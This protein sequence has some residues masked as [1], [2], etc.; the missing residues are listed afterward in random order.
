MG[1]TRIDFWRLAQGQNHAF[2]DP[3]AGGNDLVQAPQ[4]FDVKP[5][6]G[7]QCSTAIRFKYRDQTSNVMRMSR[8][9][10]RDMAA[11]APFAVSRPY[12]LERMRE[13]SARPAGSGLAWQ[14]APT[15]TPSRT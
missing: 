10:S 8:A 4:R 12:Y 13:L 14:H 2:C 5:E 1:V 6:V 11:S 15:S 9:A 7:P 3:G